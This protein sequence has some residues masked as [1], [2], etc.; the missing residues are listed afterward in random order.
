MNLKNLQNIIKR[1]GSQKKAPS[2]KQLK[3]TA[4]RVAAPAEEPYYEDDEPNVR[5]SRA[6]LVVMLLHVVAVGGIFLFSSFKK[7]G[8][9]AASP[10]KEEKTK[11]TVVSQDA[12]ADSREYVVGDEET[13]GSIASAFGI[14]RADLASINRLS[15]DA[16]VHAGDK[17]QIPSKTTIQPADL[18]VK[19]LLNQPAKQEIVKVSVT[20]PKAPMVETA[21][22]QTDL[23]V[24]Q[25]AEPVKTTEAHSLDRFYV[26]QKGDNPVGIAKKLKVKYQD[27]I[28]ANKITDPRKLQI[29]QKLIVPE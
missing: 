23:Q 29:G 18:D 24:V 1:R 16:T 7:E 22:V 17:L 19:K 3:A 20:T 9:R 8:G 27:L 6:F 21:K 15:P 14:S 26:V 13:L 4:R 11:E 25:K 10:A 28:S 2:P 12:H 5:L